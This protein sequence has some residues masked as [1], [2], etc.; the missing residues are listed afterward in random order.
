MRFIDRPAENNWNRQTIRVGPTY[1]NEQSQEKEY[2]LRGGEPVAALLTNN[3]RPEIFTLFKNHEIPL[4]ASTLKLVP[5][6]NGKVYIY[7]RFWDENFGSMN[8]APALLIYADLV[9]SGYGR[10]KEIANQ[11]LNNELQHIQ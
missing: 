1:S 10:N 9:N 3:L 5:D 7:N 11:I 4:I 6:P 8:V 2:L